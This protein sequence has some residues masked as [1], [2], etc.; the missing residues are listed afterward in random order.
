[1]T[2]N[3][4]LT[5]GDHP[6]PKKSNAPPEEQRESHAISFLEDDFQLYA[7]QSQDTDLGPMDRSRQ[8]TSD[9]T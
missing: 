4:S 6:R 9:R 7:S 2:L 5:L 3:G 8:M 1:M